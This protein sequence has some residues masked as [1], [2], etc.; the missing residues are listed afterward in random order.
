MQS[1]YRIWIFKMF[2]ILILHLICFI[3]RKYFL[4]VNENK[5]ELRRRKVYLW[6]DQNL[7]YFDNRLWE[8]KIFHISQTIYICS[9]ISLKIISNS[10]VIIDYKM[11]HGNFLEISWTTPRYG[12]SAKLRPIIF[13]FYL[14]LKKMNFLFKVLKI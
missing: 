10:N 11:F 6:N 2:W 4:E 9:W 1:E 5:K 14:Q 8:V 12:K 3:N 7:L 13:L